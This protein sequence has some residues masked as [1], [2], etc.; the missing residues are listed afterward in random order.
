MILHK[1]ALLNRFVSS[2][3]IEDQIGTKQ[4]LASFK[5]EICTSEFILMQKF[6]STGTL[7]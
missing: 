2:S 7:L 4:E 3:E 6:Y 5:C 1:G